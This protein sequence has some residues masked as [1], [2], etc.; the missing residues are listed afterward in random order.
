MQKTTKDTIE[1]LI[2]VV[3][4]LSVLVYLFYVTSSA[5][6][7]FVATIVVVVIVTVIYLARIYVKKER[8]KEKEA[9]R[10]REEHF[11]ATKNN[12]LNAL[13]AL[14]FHPTDAN[15]KQQTLDLGR[16]FATLTRQYQG[17]DAV[18]IFDEVALM[19]DINAACA[20]ATVVSGKETVNNPT[21]EERL[22]KLSKLKEKNLI[23]KE[24]YKA[25]RHKIL[26]EI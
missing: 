2:A 5:N 14:T 16:K 20:G 7:M 23:N 17:V 12:Y 21:V 10:K 18:T 11:V 26:D 25:R 24:E 3:V 9:K 15:L 19:N 22:A 4:S 13:N 6:E 1:I 8:E